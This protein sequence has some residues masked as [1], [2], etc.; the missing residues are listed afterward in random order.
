MVSHFP[1]VHSRMTLLTILN[2][3][4]LVCYMFLKCLFEIVSNELL[5]TIVTEVSSELVLS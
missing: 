4:T 1:N 3:L 2:S 5:S